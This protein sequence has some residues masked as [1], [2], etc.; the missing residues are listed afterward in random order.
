MLDAVLAPARKAPASLPSTVLIVDDEQVVLD[1]LSATLK[2]RKLAHKGVKSG[3]EA[4]ALLEKEPFG[5]LLTDKN[6]PGADGVEVIRRARELQPFCA[7]IMITGYA[8]TES[9][10]EVMRMGAIDYLE[11]PFPEMGIVVQKIEAAMRAQRT[12][13]ERNMLIE[14]IRGMQKKLSEKEHQAFQQK[15]ELQMFENVLDLRIDEATS[16]LQRR[17][18][19]LEKASRADA[20]VQRTVGQQLEDMLEWIRMLMRDTPPG[21]QKSTLRELENRL[22]SATS[23]MRSDVGD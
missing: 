22:D 3:E 10:I 6:L 12:A 20:E 1:V 23:M 19:D 2:R 11:K 14:V 4:I 17:I 7:C 9:V 15:T 5:C 8:S 16:A 21:V 13:F 18:A